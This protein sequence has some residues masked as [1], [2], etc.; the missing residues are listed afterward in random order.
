MTR[1]K[2]MCLALSGLLLTTAVS[3]PIFAAKS[4]KL[5][6]TSISLYV[7]GT[8]Q[9]K[10]KNYKKKVTWKSSNKKIATVTSKGLVKAIKKGKTVIIAKTANGKKYRCKVTV[11][12][13]KKPVVTSTPKVTPSITPVATGTPLPL[14]APTSNDCPSISPSATP[15]ISATPVVTTE[16]AV[17]ATPIATTPAITATPI[18]ATSSAVKVMNRTDGINTMNFDMLS[19]YGK[20]NS[21]FSAYSIDIALS[22]LANGAGGTTKQEILNALYTSDTDTQNKNLSELRKELLKSDK[23][24]T[25]ANSIWLDK[26]YPLGNNADK[27]FFE[28]LKTYY[29]TE[30]N[31][32]N[33]QSEET[34]GNINSWVD[35]NTKHII[36][37]ILDA[38]LAEDVKMILLNAVAFERQWVYPFA[39]GLTQKEN[40]YGNKETKETDMMSFFDKHSFRYTVQH[41][42]Q[43]IE[44]PYQ[45]SD[46]A[47][48]IF[49]SEDKTNNTYDLF[50]KLSNE[51]KL[52]MFENLGKAGYQT[53]KTVKLPKFTFETAS[54]DLF[55][56]K[57]LKNL[58]INQVFNSDNCDLNTLNP[59]LYVD[60]VLHKAKIEVMESGTKAAAVTAIVAKPTSV[61]LGPEPEYPKFIANH[62]FVYALRDTKT[63]TILFMGT[64]QD[65]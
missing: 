47:M 24:F 49:L 18:P 26:D 54:E 53:M 6:K 42:M 43:C 63:G 19:Q 23:T 55:I 3:T 36:P 20:Q 52:K 37:K 59:E 65:A 11:L 22:M 2:L 41:D 14:P 46:I 38:P 30:K 29:N 51:E 27:D 16:P 48:D 4:V 32:T 1:K 25:T 21:F 8:K 28:P 9:L 7:K 17:T 61:I 50:Q 40:F 57:K 35:S 12:G 13:A 58:G 39:P 56:K 45:D 60:E 34:L 62:S 44:L 10:L 33:L 64:M 5:N 31:V 15:A